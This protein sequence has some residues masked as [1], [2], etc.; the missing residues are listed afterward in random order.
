M[1]RKVSTQIGIS[2]DA[3]P[4]ENGNA[5]EQRSSQITVKSEGP[6]ELA[7]IIRT[8]SIRSVDST[9]DDIDFSQDPMNCKKVSVVNVSQTSLVSATEGEYDILGMAVENRRQQCESIYAHA[10]DD[11]TYSHIDNAGEK[12]PRHLNR[13][14]NDYDD[15][16]LN[17]ND[18]NN[19]FLSRSTKSL[20]IILLNE[21]VVKPVFPSRSDY[22]IM[23]HRSANE[24]CAC[25]EKCKGY[26]K[27]NI[28]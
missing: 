17:G 16:K 1:A 3:K 8:S 19:V 7:K 21:N 20:S 26:R 14:R 9:Y 22:N 11:E 6:Y 23:M 5:L 4:I 25:K 24:T 2:V 10:D 27:S 18:G 28:F 15:V 13:V 12:H